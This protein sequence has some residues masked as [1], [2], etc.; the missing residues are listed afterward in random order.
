MSVERCSTK[1]GFYWFA[2]SIRKK[3][4][5]KTTVC[6]FWCALLFL[7]LIFS[8]FSDLGKHLASGAFTYIFLKYWF[9]KKVQANNEKNK[10]SRSVR[11]E[12]RSRAKDDIKRV[13]QAVDKVRHWWVNK[14]RLFFGSI[15]NNIRVFCLLQG[16]KMGDDWWYNNENL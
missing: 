9:K 4:E 2:K 13:M 12:T 1:I 14:I 16:E 8:A 3:V 11:A 5:T 6:L 15:V 10:M 7:L